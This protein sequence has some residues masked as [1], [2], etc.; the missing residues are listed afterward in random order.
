MLFL[1]QYEILEKLKIAKTCDMVPIFKRLIWLLSAEW[2][3]VLSLT[4]KLGF[5]EHK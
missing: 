5:E 4:H 2:L 3:A 1:K